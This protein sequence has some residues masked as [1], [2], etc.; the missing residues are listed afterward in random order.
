MKQFV[1][2]LLLTAAFL[3][4][5]E[6]LR[7]EDSVDDMGAT[8]TVVAYAEDRSQLEGA[9]E[10]AFDEVRRLDSVLS[11][12]KSDSELSRVNRQAAERPVPVSPEVFDLLSACLDF[13][14]Q[15][16]GS[17]DI[18]VGPLMR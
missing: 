11:N 14:R 16:E 8:Y 1:V 17:F 7:L 10:A 9:V 13:S 4:A 12:Y 5:G 3:Q 18:T 2:I 6:M 15:S